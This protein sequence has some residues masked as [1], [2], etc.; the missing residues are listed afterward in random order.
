MININDSTVAVETSAEL[1]SVLEGS[2]SITLIY[3]A[4]DIVLAQGISI[5]ATKTEVTIDGFYPLNGNGKIHTYTDMNSASSADTIGIRTASSIH[6]TVQNL[7]VVGKNYYGLIYV[8]ENTNHQNVVVTYKNITYNGPQITYHPS[9]LSEYK[10]LTINIIDSTACVANEVAETS[11]LQIG[12]KTTI[13]HNSVGNSAFWFRGTSPYLEI[14]EDADVNITT[15]RDIAY[16]AS[17]IKFTINANANFNIRTKYGFFRDNSHQ[18]SSI[19]LDTASKLSIIQEQTNGSNATISCRGD[20]TINENSS[21]YIE[22]NYKNTAPLILFNTTSSILNVNNPKSVILYNNSYQ[23]LSFA[24]TSTFNIKCGKLD[25]WLTSPNLISTG[26]VENN[27]L[28]SWY[29]SNDV[30]FEITATV[31]SSKTTITTNNLSE[32]E[33]QSLPN[34]NLLTFQTAKT[35][36]LIAFGNL[37]LQNAPTIIEF[38]KP[39][40]NN[41]PLILGRKEKAI[42]MSVTDS[43]AISSDWYLY[44]YIDKPLSTSDEKFSLPDSLIFIDDSNKITT[45]ST[46]PTL[47]YTGTGNDGNTKVTN[48]T[49]NEKTGILFK[50]INPLTN[51]E[52]YS[53]L[54]K[55]I[56]TNEIL[57]INN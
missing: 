37:D 44:V 40:I 24:N 49:W 5:L 9:G 56:L 23:C 16:V 11:K 20:F 4:N 26:V 51:G 48:I 54:V 2:N 57:D 28:Y 18:A 34:L 15:T 33:T 31:T 38:Q 13:T 3:L 55:W 30:N 19:L 42:V 17:Y 43:R 22:A 50:V 1:K 53:T 47:I 35:L 52:S 10:D 29:K 12:G 41:N 39:L 7:N 36:R 25:Y 27:P 45:L 14:L 46:T 8:S 6:V 21:L 32:A